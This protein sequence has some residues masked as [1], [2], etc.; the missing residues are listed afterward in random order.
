M[1]R[2]VGIL[3]IFMMFMLV[4]LTGCASHN[5]TIG[6]FPDAKKLKQIQPNK[7]SKKDVEKI[8]GKPKKI[9]V[10]S[11]TTE[12]WIYKTIEAEYTDTY[13]AKKALSFAP[14][15]FLGTVLGAVDT[16]PSQTGVIQTLS[17]DFDKHGLLKNIQKEMEHF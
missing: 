8:L 12:H 17:L 5:S 3:S 11:D 16:G 4:S 14:V 15:P 1:L 10:G 13:A 7:S 2:Q 6:V 9:I